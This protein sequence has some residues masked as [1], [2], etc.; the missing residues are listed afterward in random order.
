MLSKF[1]DFIRGRRGV[2]MLAVLINAAFGFYPAPL[3]DEDEGFTAEVAREML[4]KKEFV[5]L[6][7]N[8]EHRYDKPPL[9]FWVIAGSLH[10]LGNNEF[11][12]RFPG[13]L[14]SLLLQL[15]IY[16]FIRKRYGEDR[17]VTAGLFIV[18]ALQFTLMSKSAIADPFL[19]LL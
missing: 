17:A 1:K 14:A 4:E 2:L 6:E 12:A 8:F 7:S 13:I 16:T 10:F 9:A 11:A 18:G 3:F 15:M 5:L 19:Y